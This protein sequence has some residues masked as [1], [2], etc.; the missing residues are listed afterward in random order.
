MRAPSCWLPMVLFLTCLQQGRRMD[1]CGAT[2]TPWRLLSWFPMYR[3]LVFVLSNSFAIFLIAPCWQ[4]V[5][6]TYAI[7]FW[8]AILMC[9]QRSDIPVGRIWDYMHDMIRCGTVYYGSTARVSQLRGWKG[10]LQWV[11]L[12]VCRQ[13][14]STWRSRA[15]TKKNIATATDELQNDIDIIKICTSK[16]VYI[17]I[18]IYEI[19]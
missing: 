8:S 19:S 2:F 1:F 9:M 5:G 10:V 3:Q 6:I 17:Y 7:F 18:Y 11:L 13:V 12:A 14:S 4:L 15:K 16:M